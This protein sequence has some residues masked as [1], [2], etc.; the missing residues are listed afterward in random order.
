MF[1]F[2]NTS[3]PQYLYRYQT[4]LQAIS[5]SNKQ[6]NA[7]SVRRQHP[8]MDGIPPPYTVSMEPPPLYS[9]RGLP[10]PAR[11]PLPPPVSN[12][13]FVE[14]AMQHRV[15]TRDASGNWHPAKTRSTVRYRNLRYPK[16]MLTPILRPSPKSASTHQSVPQT[17]TPQSAAPSRAST[18]WAYSAQPTLWPCAQQ[19]SP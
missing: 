6:H 17:S 4:R 7:Q 2:R 13:F 10:S 19:S 11:A 12:N 9:P 8:K 14:L 18:T 3:H 1:L 5:S 16:H 15:V